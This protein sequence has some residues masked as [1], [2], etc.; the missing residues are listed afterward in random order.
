[1]TLAAEA[2][3]RA[4]ITPR[5]AGA[6]HPTLSS[7]LA[8]TKPEA[9]RVLARLPDIG[10]PPAAQKHITNIA[11]PD[12]KPAFIVPRRLKLNVPAWM[13]HKVALV[14]VAAV[15]LA[16][17]IA[18]T[19]NRDQHTRRL[20]SPPAWNG[21]VGQPSTGA[22]SSAAADVTAAQ[23]P[24]VTGDDWAPPVVTKAEAPPALQAD[25]RNGAP[26]FDDR[27]P[28]RNFG[29]QEPTA[30]RDVRTS[31]APPEMPIRF[32]TAGPRR[33]VVPAGAPRVEYNR[34]A[35]PDELSERGRRHAERDPYEQPR[36]GRRY[37]ESPR[38]RFDG[39][40]RTPPF[41]STVTPHDDA[42]SVFH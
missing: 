41:P 37:E 8:S 6:S 5:S 2:P 9:P 29:E 31:E 42:R 28:V 30:P 32:P 20:D 39:T 36:V 7:A 26:A 1:M 35:P 23:P 10:A 16:V 17:L 15:A 27:E 40:I 38:A 24:V 34:F 18:S 22:T 13:S 21:Q 14:A 3:A 4:P 19:R 33:P 12:S 11:S 25:R